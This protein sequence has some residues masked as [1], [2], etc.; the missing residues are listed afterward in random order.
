MSRRRPCGSASISPRLPELVDLPWELLYDGVLDRFLAASN[1]T[2]LVRTLDVPPAPPR[3]PEP[4]PLRMLVVVS[5]PADRPLLDA[6]TEWNRVAEAARVPVGDGRLLLQRL[7]DARPETVRDA[8]RTSRP[9]VLHYVGHG[10]YD[11]ATQQGTLVLEGEDGNGRSLRAEEVASLV[12]EAP[13]LRLVV[14]NSC[15]G[16]RSSMVDPFAGTAQALLGL[17]VP[18]VVG[19]QF[20]VSDD[21]AIGFSR[22][23]YGALCA[24]APVETAVGEA[25]LAMMTEGEGSEWATPVLYAAG[26][27]GPILAPRPVAAPAPARTP[28]VLAGELVVTLDQAH[29]VRLDPNPSPPV[30][31]RRPGR[32]SVLPP[33]FPLLLGR[34]REVAAVRAAVEGGSVQIHAETGWGK[35]ALLRG[36]AV[37]LTGGDGPATGDGTAAGQ[38]YLRGLSRT[39]LDVLQAVFE[40]CFEADPPVQG[41]PDQ[42]A[43]WLADTR[44]VVQVD[45]LDV[46]AGDVADLLRRAPAGRFVLASRTRTI[47][48]PGQAIELAGVP[49]EAGLQL[50]ELELG[51]HLRPE[52][53]TAAERI[54]SALRGSPGRVLAEAER[55]WEEERPLE[56]VARALATAS[57]PAVSEAGR[58]VLGALAALDPAPVHAEH[59]VALAGLTDPVPTLESLERAGVIRDHSPLYN[60]AFPL[61]DEARASLDAD[62]WVPAALARLSTWASGAGEAEIV[63]D[64]D[65]ILAALHAGRRAG[66]DREVVDLGRAVEGALVA[67]RRWGQWG[68][69]LGLEAEAATALGDTAAQ[70]WALHQLG[71]RAL[72]LGDRVA[73]R[74]LLERALR[75]R[76]DLGDTAGAEVTRH[77]LGLLGPGGPPGRR[78]PDRPRP[79]RRWLRWVAVV[80][81]VVVAAVAAVVLV[82]RSGGAGEVALEP[83]ALAFG[84][85]VIGRDQPPGRVVLRNTGSGDVHVG[86]VRLD[87]LAPDFAV[88]D[89]CSGAPVPP[90]GSCTI[91]VAF[92]PSVAG[93]QATD[94]LILDD[95]QAGGHRVALTGTGT[96]PPGP[97]V[98]LDRQPV[99]F[100]EVAVRTE[101]RAT[102]TLTNDG[103][104]TLNVRAIE[105]PDPP[106]LVSKDG[107]T[108]AAL[109]PGDACS[110]EVVFQP[111]RPGRA[112]GE[113]GFDDDAPGS[114]HVVALVGTGVGPDITVDRL[115]QTDPPYLTSPAASVF[116]DVLVQNVIAVPVLVEVRNRGSAPAGP[117]ELGGRPVD[118]ADGLPFQVVANGGLKLPCTADPVATQRELPPGGVESLKAI[119]CVPVPQTEP[120]PPA[121]LVVVIGDDCF[122]E[123]PPECRILELDEGNNASP[124]IS[125]LV[126]LP[127]LVF[128]RF[129]GTGLTVRNDRQR[130][131]RAVL[132]P[133][134]VELLVRLRAPPARGGGHARVRLLR[135]R[136]DR[137]HHRSPRRGGRAG[138]AELGLGAVGLLDLTQ[139]DRRSARYLSESGYR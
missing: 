101:A 10:G 110:I 100:G 97:V 45:D 29:G 132:G 18:A 88:T 86:D 98:R 38:L 52:E 131:L 139:A 77:N 13:D 46:D 33:P 51:H 47:A 111:D 39:G 99:D 40:A 94:L 4:P 41:T 31:R 130:G 76:E 16:S 23:F 73:A 19:M 104:A 84:S 63:R 68:S 74:G 70:G 75:T 128:T 124:A 126:P 120:I 56:E 121:V 89:G 64:A 133:R 7:D 28:S 54:W 20:E 107:C 83:K 103:D 136:D 112:V 11:P 127:D 58:R 135:R 43:A 106:F 96:A 95:T 25:R 93:D 119:L 5:G 12:A 90:G 59:L 8:L 137:R 125:V 79:P 26:D 15:E 17:G 108:R 82:S 102:V 72:S 87:P 118:R 32:V 1:R 66:R 37:G 67:G 30:P 36:I 85:A 81:A 50:I 109:E 123:P 91:T 105:P 78:P 134:G 48:A 55:A 60:L 80:T 42:L 27:Q 116:L 62:R 22:G 71:S 138:R 115:E 21:A 57:A 14:L 53:R 44:I 92:A 113:L 34:E 122:G 69:A 117:F 65:A 2:P 24:G 61:T 49:V 129:D 114:P 3:P 9:H 6:A 35:T